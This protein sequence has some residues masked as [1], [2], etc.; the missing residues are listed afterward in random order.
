MLFEF[1]DKDKD[2][3]INYI[4]LLEIINLPLDQSRFELIREVFGRLDS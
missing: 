4:E 1:L 3:I 2:G